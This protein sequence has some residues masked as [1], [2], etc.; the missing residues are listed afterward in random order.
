MDISKD[1]F[2]MLE[3]KCMIDKPVQCGSYSMSIVYFAA[4]TAVI[5]LVAE[6]GRLRPSGAAS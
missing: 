1:N 2:Q 3:A 5:S 6:S 4:Y